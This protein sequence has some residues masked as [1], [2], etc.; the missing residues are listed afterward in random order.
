MIFLVIV[1]RVHTRKNTH[2]KKDIFFIW[3]LVFYF[4]LVNK[5]SARLG[6]KSNIIE[7]RRREHVSSDKKVIQEFLF[8]EIFNLKKL[9]CA[10]PPKFLKFCNKERKSDLCKKK[11]LGYWTSDNKKKKNFVFNKSKIYQSSFSHM[12]KNNPKPKKIRKIKSW[13]K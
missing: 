10:S 1:K 7:K 8:L 2:R 11:A 12:N 6:W 9:R 13:L 3:F 4:K 5:H